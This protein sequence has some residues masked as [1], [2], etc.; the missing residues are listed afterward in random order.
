MTI[1]PESVVSIHYT[2]SAEDGTQLDSSEGKQPLTVMLGKRFLIEG[3]E[4][5]LQNKEQGEKFEVDIAPEQAYGQRMDELVQQVP[6]DM[7]DGMD[8]EV[9]MSFRATTEQGE[10]SVMIIDVA[11]DHVVVDGN[12][13]LAGVP[14]KFEV[15]VIEV[16]EPTQE[17]IEHGHAHGPGS[18][19]DH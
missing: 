19:N 6:K 11:D 13:P 7:F 9:G 18:G 17:E 12:H 16:R 10:Q 15:E 5:A 3:L 1:T 8:V 14:L 2:V 4:D